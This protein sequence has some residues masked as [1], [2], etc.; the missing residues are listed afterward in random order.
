VIDA[1]GNVIGAYKDGKAVGLD[2]KELGRVEKNAALDAN[3]RVIDMRSSQV[4]GAGGEL[5]GKLVDGKLVDANGKVIGEQGEIVRDASGKVL[6]RVVDGKLVDADGKVIGTVKDGVAIG[7]DG[8]TL[9]KVEQVVLGSDGRPMADAVLE[10]RDANGNVIGTV[11]G[12]DVLDAQGRK[13][14]TV[15]DGKVY[16]LAGNPTDGAEIGLRKDAQQVV[17][18][19]A[20]NVLGQVRGDT[21]YGADGK[22]I[23]KLVDG[24][25]VDGNGNVISR[26][27]SVGVE[28]PRDT[29][30]TAAR[31]ESTRTIQFI[32][33][34][35]G[36]Q[37]VLP[38]QTLRLE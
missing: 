14:G 35:T 33:G 5:S 28:T 7:S 11:V 15:R 38:V 29:A 3:G 6:G 24:K 2:G 8:K 22:A 30:P 17:R 26:G 37:G 19:A 10:V 1:N 16:D 27:V 12:N 36:K 13:V 4:Q 34:G 31:R 32:P 9:G 25:V 18:D 21:L 23:G 20:G